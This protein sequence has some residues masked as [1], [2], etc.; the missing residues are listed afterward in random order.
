M[1]EPTIVGAQRERTNTS[2]E[3]G[4]ASGAMDRARRTA[5]ISDPITFIMPP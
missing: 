2:V 3:K 5:G 1:S 4:A